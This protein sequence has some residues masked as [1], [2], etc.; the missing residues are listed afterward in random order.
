MKPKGAWNCCMTEE[1][2][3]ALS[4]H[5]KSCCSLYFKVLTVAFLSWMEPRRMSC[6]EN[7]ESAFRLL[8]PA[9]SGLVCCWMEAIG[10]GGETNADNKVRLSLSSAFFSAAVVPDG[11][12]GGEAVHGAHMVKNKLPKCN[13]S[14]MLN[15]Q[16][17]GSLHAS[18]NRMV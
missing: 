10:L 8:P 17:W 9:P 11:C 1:G 18:E 3:A 2:C 6:Q 5:A 12:S 15:T 14:L 4:L 13:E 7:T 16:D